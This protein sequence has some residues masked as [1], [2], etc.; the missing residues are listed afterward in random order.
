MWSCSS[1]FSAVQILE[2]FDSSVSG[3]FR[4]SYGGQ[5][6]PDIPHDISGPAM[7]TILSS[8]H[9]KQAQATPAEANREENAHGNFQW[10]VIH[11]SHRIW[12]LV[13]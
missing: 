10:R 1:D 12:Y 9:G 4:L 11:Q 7:Q 5:I 8:L 13:E 2:S 6:S 3:Y